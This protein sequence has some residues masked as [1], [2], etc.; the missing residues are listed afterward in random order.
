MSEPIYYGG[1]QF[2]DGTKILNTSK[3]Q[4]PP[5]A[6]LNP[7][8]RVVNTIYQN[9][10]RKIRIV[11]VSCLLEVFSVNDVA[12]FEFYVDSFTPPTTHVSSNQVYCIAAAAVE[13][14]SAV[15]VVFP[16]YYYK[17][18]PTIAGTGVVV[19]QKWTEWDFFRVI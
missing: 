11:S 17:V 9:T 2:P 10:S 18:V 5:S 13:M 19:L 8:T 12:G 16:N 15:L 3:Y 14:K 7:A 6:Y 1:L 4:A